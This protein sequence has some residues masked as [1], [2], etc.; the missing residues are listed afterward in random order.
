MVFEAYLSSSIS[1]SL[2]QESS[3]RERRVLSQ[4]P[5]VQREVLDLELRWIRAPLAYLNIHV[6]TRPLVKDLMLLPKSTL[7]WR[8]PTIP[9]SCNQ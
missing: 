3:L 5:P 7:A 4:I 1:L 2:Y 9:A 6:S 8:E